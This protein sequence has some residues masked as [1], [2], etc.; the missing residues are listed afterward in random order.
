MELTY[1]SR[2]MV[3]SR[4][5]RDQTRYIL[6]TNIIR[7]ESGTLNVDDVMET[8]NHF[9]CIDMIIDNAGHALSDVKSLDDLLDSH[10]R[11]ERIHLF[12]GRRQHHDNKRTI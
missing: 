6:A 4:L 9:K 8:A 5:T 7:V 12:S 10:Y 11:L 1:N 3:G 2:R